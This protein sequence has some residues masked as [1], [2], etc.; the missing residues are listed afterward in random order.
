M[1]ELYQ[2]EKG[3]IR[4]NE[5]TNAIEL[6][7]KK[8]QEEKTYKMMFTKILEFIKE[9][10][11]TAFFSDIRKEGVVGPESSKWVQTEIM[12]QAFAAGLKKIAVVMDP[13]VFQE[14]Y[15]KNIVKAAGNDRMK[16]FGSIETAN[17]WILES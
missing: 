8:H 16:Y 9:Y 1:K 15:L 17:S 3:D 10:R 2:H 7:W 13:D 4:Y 14:F 5:K 11:A 12:P 6:I